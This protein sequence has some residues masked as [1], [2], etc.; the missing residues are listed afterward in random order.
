MHKNFKF[1]LQNATLKIT[2][3]PAQKTLIFFMLGLRP[4]DIKVSAYINGVN[5]ERSN[6]EIEYIA[7]TGK[8]K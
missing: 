3:T 7:P 5:F 1:P 8:K 4:E 2:W 6:L